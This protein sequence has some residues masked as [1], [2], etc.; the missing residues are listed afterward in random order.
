MKFS[1]I[2]SAAAAIAAAGMM[3]VAA[4]AGIVKPVE[5]APAGSKC[6][7]GGWL[8]QLFN[9]GGVEE[10]KDAT[11]YDIDYSKVAKLSV[12]F[13]V[14]DDGNREFWEG[15]TGGSLILSINGGDIN[16]DS[17]A[18]KAL[19][20]KY[21]WPGQNYWGVSD[22]DLGIESMNP[23]EVLKTEKVGD[24]TYRL[25][26]NVF[27][28]P[29]ANGDAKEIGCMQASFSEWGGDPFAY[30]EV[31]KFEIMD[32]SGNVLMTFDSNA[33]ADKPNLKAAGASSG[34]ASASTPSN[35]VDT[36]VEGV[37]TVVGVAALAAGAVVLSRKRK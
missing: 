12:T 9:V 4:S 30:I 18:G 6:D 13:S 1:K 20:N 3:T 2:V 7:A 32:A 24:Y 16:Q 37:A 11:E 10:G 22:E 34:D 25:T 27:E 29:L 14:V 36:G 15:G 19:W 33:K 28:N 8:V 21:N 26:S 5:N 31:Q 35:N 23:D 17:D